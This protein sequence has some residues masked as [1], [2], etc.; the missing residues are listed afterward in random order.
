MK[1]FLIILLAVAAIPFASSG[2]II[3]GEKSFGPKLGYISHNKSAVA[4]LVFQYNLSNMLRISPEASVAFRHNNQD[5]F[6]LDLNFETPFSFSDAGNVDLYPLAGVAFC[7]WA[8][9]GV[10][11]IDLKDVTT[12]TNRLG[13]NLGAGFDLQC[14]STLKVNIEARYTIVKS[15]SGIVATAGISY[16]F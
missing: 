16:L 13:V 14:S 2:R 11:P 10:E 5:A 1:R 4:G 15:Y 3:K 8:S 6:M 7:S 12:H 9:H